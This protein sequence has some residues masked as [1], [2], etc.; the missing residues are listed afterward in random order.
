MREKHFEVMYVYYYKRPEYMTELDLDDLWRI[1]ELDEEWAQFY[2]LREFLK[3]QVNQLSAMNVPEVN[4]GRLIVAYE[5]VKKM[6]ELEN[7]R[8]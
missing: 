6:D 8:V 5:N 7:I 2:K 4:E 1:D 3:A